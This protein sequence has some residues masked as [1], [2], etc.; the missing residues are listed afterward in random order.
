MRGRGLACCRSIPGS[1]NLCQISGSA[2]TQPHFNHCSND[3]AD[4]MLQKPIGIGLY[5]DLVIVA[6]HG[7]SMQMTDGVGI[8]R[9]ASF[10]GRKVL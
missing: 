8:V 10:E 6:N 3:R 9:Q 2:F 5:V 7:Q 1:E 4:H